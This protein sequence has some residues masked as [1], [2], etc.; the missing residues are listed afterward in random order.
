MSIRWVLD[1]GYGWVLVSSL[2]KIKAAADQ[3]LVLQMC[4]KRSKNDR[5][6]T[7]EEYTRQYGNF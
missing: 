3:Q 5:I 2:G 4:G 6:M 1:E 7:T